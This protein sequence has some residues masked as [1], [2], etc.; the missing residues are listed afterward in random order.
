MGRP[1]KK[2]TPIQINRLK[3]IVSKY[4]QPGDIGLK[5]KEWCL[6]AKEYHNL[7]H[8]VSSKVASSLF[9]E[10][11]KY[12]SGDGNTEK[13][14]KT[15]SKQPSATGDEAEKPNNVSEATGGENKVDKQLEHHPFGDVESLDVVSEEDDRVSLVSCYSEQSCNDS[16]TCFAQ[17]DRDKQAANTGMQKQLG[18]EATTERQRGS[19]DAMQVEMSLEKAGENELAEIRSLGFSEGRDS[20]DRLTY[21]SRGAMSYSDEKVVEKWVEETAGQSRPSESLSN[22][23]RF[24]V[25]V[26][27]KTSYGTERVAG[28]LMRVA[29]HG[30]VQTGKPRNEILDQIVADTI[31]LSIPWNATGVNSEQ[32]NAESKLTKENLFCNDNPR[33]GGQEYEKSIPNESI[34]DKHSPNAVR[35]MTN[36][37]TPSRLPPLDFKGKEINLPLPQSW[38]D[39]P[40]KKN[41]F[42]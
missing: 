10:Y 5:K 15:S 29:E 40:V 18:V 38:R 7:K 17:T 37:V 12:I 42:W 22:Q 19:N 33:N 30:S 14:Q 1:R 23:R 13:V 9:Y 31:A 3:H 41:E 32:R 4:L 25:D 16:A 39:I 11:R 21:N 35:L 28:I 27:H 26:E 2:G 24:I 36:I 6:I 34:A 8:K 20:E